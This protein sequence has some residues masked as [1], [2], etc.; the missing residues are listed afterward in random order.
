[1]S[2]M[3]ELPL[4]SGEGRETDELLVV[5]D[6]VAR[7][8]LGGAYLRPSWDH[9]GDIC[10]PHKV[11]AEQ[12]GAAKKNH[13]HPELAASQEETNSGEQTAK[14]IT[15]KSLRFGFDISFTS[16]GHFF[17]PSWLGGFGIAWVRKNFLDTEN[18]VGYLQH[19]GDVPFSR[20]FSHKALCAFTTAYGSSDESVEHVCSARYLTKN[21]VAL[22]AKR[23][24]GSNPDVSSFEVLCLVLGY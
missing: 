22:M 8:I 3:S 13:F 21:K 10:N 1:M 7:R 6:G 14:F 20:A 16:N 2:K 12:I 4:V 11:T 19:G 18:Y 17:F 24:W 5:R 9:I 23:V 15:P